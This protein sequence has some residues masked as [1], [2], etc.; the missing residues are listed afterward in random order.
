M[1]KYTLTFDYKEEPK[2]RQV[3]SGLDPSDT[4]I[5]EIVK[6]VEE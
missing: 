6:S 1:T 3:P 4:T 2:F 5:L